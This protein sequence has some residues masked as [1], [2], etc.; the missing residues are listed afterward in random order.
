MWRRLGGINL[1]RVQ[2]I[3][4]GVMLLFEWVAMYFTQA[5]LMS[6]SDRR[7]FYG[8]LF[9]VLFLGLAECIVGFINSF[10]TVRTPLLIECGWHKRQWTYSITV[11]AIMLG[12]AFTPSLARRNTVKIWERMEREESNKRKNTNTPRYYPV[13]R[14]SMA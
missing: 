2:M 6:W 3:L 13:E 1:E 14:T 4:I 5:G 10:K 11:L 12:V 9:A 7:L 8:V